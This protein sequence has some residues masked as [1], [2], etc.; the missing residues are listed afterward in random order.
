MPILTIAGSTRNDSSN[1]RLLQAIAEHLP[2]YDFVHFNNL[3]DLP[4][5][6]PEIDQHPWPEAVLLWRQAL[7]EASAVI[8]STPEY[9][10]N[11]PALLKNALEWT[12][13]SGELSHKP[14]LPITFTAHT[15]R[16]ERAMQS[17]LWSLEALDARVVVQLPMYQNELTQTESGAFVF[18]DEWLEMLTEAV[19]ML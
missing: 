12:T 11:M 16:G 13:S 14:V 15:P 18:S 2:Q 9:I 6:Q 7:A 17:L 3:A 8:I 10:H 4:L 1:I 5:F 19:G